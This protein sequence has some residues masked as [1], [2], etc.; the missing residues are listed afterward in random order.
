MVKGIQTEGVKFV[1]AAFALL[2][3]FGLS[4]PSVSAHDPIILTEEQVQPDLGPLLL[5]GTIS[6]ALYGSVSGPDDSRGFRV[7]FKEG[8]RLYVSLLIPD[9]EP[10]KELSSDLLPVLTMTDPFGST[11]MLRPDQRVAFAEPFTGTNYVRLFDYV[12][13][14]TEGMYSFSVSAKTATRFTVS[15]GEKEMFGTPVEGVTNRTLG[16]DGVMAW[17]ATPPLEESSPSAAATSTM[18]PSTSSSSEAP[19]AEIA[20]TNGEE[21]QGPSAS[22][23]WILV[24]VA[25]LGVLVM[26]F[27]V[28]ALLLRASRRSRP[29]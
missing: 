7:A 23:N 13:T 6:F 26:I 21:T 1:V 24:L 18:A 27:A 17:Y 5:D 11:T 9:L 4:S 29:G 8:D 10:E 25:G 15:V 14:A 2:L 3:S 28:R 16:V 20:E 19:M 12:A 22:V